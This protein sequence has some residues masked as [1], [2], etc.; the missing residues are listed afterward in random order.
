[1]TRPEIEYVSTAPV[2]LRVIVTIPV[3]LPHAPVREFIVIP[4]T[5]V[6]GRNTTDFRKWLGGSLKPS[7][8]QSSENNNNDPER[9]SQH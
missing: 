7:P 5:F 9:Q 4:A 3:S 8:R 1:M 6:R 2:D